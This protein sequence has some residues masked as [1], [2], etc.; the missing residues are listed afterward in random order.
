M[1]RYRHLPKEVTVSRI[2]PEGEL[3]DP[4]FP[5]PVTIERQPE[6]HVDSFLGPMPW[7]KVSWKRY[8]HLKAEVLEVALSD[9][10]A[11]RPYINCDDGFYYLEVISDCDLSYNYERI[12]D[13]QR[14]KIE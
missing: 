13:E 14:T 7:F 8:S 1:P 5:I 9:V 10:L 3:Q 2:T 4:N 11:A 6:F 12:D